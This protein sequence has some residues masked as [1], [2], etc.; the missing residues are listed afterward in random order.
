[1][2][3]LEIVVTQPGTQRLR[4]APRAGIGHGIGPVPNQRLNEALRLTVSLRP[5]RARACQPHAGARRALVKAATQRRPAVIGQHPMEDDPAA[6]KPADGTAKKGGRRR[7]GLV[8]QDFDVG[9]ATV[10]VDRDVDVFPARPDAVT[11]PAAVEPMTDAQNAAEG[12][13]IEVHELAGARP[14]NSG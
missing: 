9:G 13:D 11:A 5:I 1:V 10:I 3:P 4:T 8:G 7:T 12:F 2:R 6:G 14:L